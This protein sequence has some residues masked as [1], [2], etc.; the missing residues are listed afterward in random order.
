MHLNV[1]RHQRY[2]QRNNR[3]QLPNKNE[4]R[5]NRQISQDHSR[6]NSAKN[7][8]VKFNLQHQV[9]IR[10]FIIER[11]QSDQK[12]VEDQLQA[13]FKS[14]GD[15]RTLKVQVYH[16]ISGTI[17]KLLRDSKATINYIGTREPNTPS[18]QRYSRNSHTSNMTRFPL[19]ISNPSEIRIINIFEDEQLSDASKQINY[20]QLMHLK[21]AKENNQYFLSINLSKSLNTTASSLH[22]QDEFNF[23]QFLQ[24]IQSSQPE[25]HYK[26]G[27][28]QHYS[29]YDM[30]QQTFAI[31][32]LNERKQEVH[33]FN[34]N[35]QVLLFQAIKLYSLNLNHIQSS[36][37]EQQNI[38]T[39]K[40]IEEREMRLKQ[41]GNNIT[42]RLRDF[43]KEDKAK[44]CLKG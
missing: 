42:R 12:S 13:A 16:Q 4:V 6:N 1:P 17:A 9:S 8:L 3:N 28:I 14:Y 2:Q 18:A 15:L 39:I 27:N 34:I 35:E 44:A 22:N 37:I 26:K 43:L 10:N 31:S 7:V 36:S 29:G 23:I 21:K 5:D 33:K 25:Y 11:I 20:Q 24:F 19:K 41:K 30:R 40:M 32:N 38:Q